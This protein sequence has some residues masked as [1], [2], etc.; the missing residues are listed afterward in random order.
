M[1]AVSETPFAHR[2][3]SKRRFYRRWWFWVVVGICLV[4]IASACWVGARA[5]Q[6]KSELE[7]AHALIAPLKAEAL[8]LDT[9]GA[10]KTLGVINKHTDKAIELTSDPVWRATEFVPVL[11]KNFTAVRQL[12]AVTSS[13]MTDVV[14]PLIGVADQV[15]PASFAPKDGAIDISPLTAA[16]PAVKQAQAGVEKAVAQVD[17]IDTSGT[18]SQVAAAKKKVSALLG[19]AAPLVGTLN[20]ILPLLPPA[21]GSEA[22]RTYVVMFQNNAEA[23]ALGGAALSFAVVKVD[24]GRIE[25]GETMPAVGGNFVS[26]KSPVMPLPLGTAELYQGTLGTFIANVT[27]R[28][29]FTTAAELTQEMWKRD[30][31]YAVDGILSI[32]PVALSYILRATDPIT[33]PSGDVLTSTSLVPLLLNTVYQRYNTRNSGRDNAAQDKVYNEA[34]SATFGALTNGKL[35]A[36]K[37]IAALTQGWNEHRV[38]Y[39]SSH[40]DEEAQLTDIGLNGEPPVSDAKTDRV[41]VYFLDNVGSKMNFYLHQAVHLSQATC[42]PDNRQS[43]RV[44]VDLTNTIQPAAVKSLSPSITG[45][46]KLEKLSPGVQRMIVLLYAP[47]GASIVGATM[48]GAAVALEAWHDTDYPVGRLVVTVPP[49]ATVNLSYDVVAAKP[50]KKALEALVTPMVN[51]TPVDTVPLDCATVPK[52]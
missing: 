2:A 29:S 7:S 3:R 8:K 5:L 35:D 4:A 46:W 45:Q 10:T 34:V 27:S 43:Y 37:L 39:W 48:G 24:K 22:P 25:L 51:A 31:G 23:R 6:A 17:A 42:R 36:K 41:G 30:Q 14:K 28:P 13:V 33:L 16:I 52:G 26:S 32:D 18:I 50:G 21:L 19:S 47:P 1:S 20:S 15:D 40:K 12:A 9:S 44:S 11:G 49:G 38:L